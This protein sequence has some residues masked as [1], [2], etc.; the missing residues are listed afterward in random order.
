MGPNGPVEMNSY[1]NIRIVVGARIAYI[2]VTS[3]Y[4]YRKWP[5]VVVTV[6]FSYAF[7]QITKIFRIVNR[8]Q[9][10]DHVTIH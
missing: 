7:S 2:L 10:C 5:K 4:S 6:F 8:L 1:G 3:I 9:L